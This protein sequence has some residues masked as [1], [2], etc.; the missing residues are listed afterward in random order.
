[1]Q[2]KREE[3]RILQLKKEQELQRQLAEMKELEAKRLQEEKE[4]QLKR[5]MEEKEMELNRLNQ[6]VRDMQ[7]LV[8]F[9][10]L[11]EPRKVGDALIY[12]QKDEILLLD[13]RHF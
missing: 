6:Q 1:M 9:S 4:T 5:E 2:A 10:R 12:L 13:L 7:F 11:F 8:F 3:E